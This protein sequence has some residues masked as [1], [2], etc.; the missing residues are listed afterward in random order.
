MT[1]RE[2]W[3]V[4]DRFE[5]AIAEYCGAP[6][7]VSVDSCTNALYLC[8]KHCWD[9]APNAEAWVMYV[10]KRTYAGVVRAALNADL[11]PTFRDWNWAGEY[12]LRVGRCV[13][14]DAAR[15]LRRG[16]YHSG[17]W[18]CLSFQATKHLPIGRG[19]AILCDRKEDY[20]WFRKAR[21]DGRDIE[22]DLWKQEEFGW[23]IHCYMTPP[24]A[25]RGLWLLGGLKDNNEPLPGEYPDLSKKRWL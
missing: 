10:P 23:G 24:D 18:T 19:G 20:D 8:F 12:D 11:S 16:M 1:G 14:V 25:A 5:R 9:V 21:F 4:V 22:S 15:W 17:T 6:Y 2:A 3:E 13:I 7:A